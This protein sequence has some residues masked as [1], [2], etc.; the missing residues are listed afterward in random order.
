MLEAALGYYFLDDYEGEII[1]E[2]QAHE[3]GVVEGITRA[4]HGY[5]PFKDNY[6]TVFMASGKGIKKGAVVEKMSLV[7]E[8][9]TL[10]ELMELK[11]DDVDGR[12]IGEFLC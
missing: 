5:S 8:A 6:T 9:P 11:L 2:I 7:D 10:A 12:I 4:T 1:K 3:P